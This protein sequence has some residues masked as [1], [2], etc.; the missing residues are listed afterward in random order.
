MQAAASMLSLESFIDGHGGLTIVTRLPRGQMPAPS[1]EDLTAVAHVCIT[2]MICELERRGIR[3]EHVQRSRIHAP[4]RRWLP[5]L[6]AS[7]DFALR[8]SKAASTLMMHTADSAGDAFTMAFDTRV[9]ARA[10]PDR[11]DTSSH[12]D[13]FSQ[14]LAA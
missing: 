3:P 10:T 8:H 1:A 11:A 9:A 4:D 13:R 12:P 6:L 2:L 14:G 7:R 5:A